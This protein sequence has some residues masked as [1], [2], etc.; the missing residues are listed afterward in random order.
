MS[1]SSFL[2]SANATFVEDLYSEYLKDPNSVL[3]EWK[4]FFDNLD[5]DHAAALKATL[6]PNWQG[7]RYE[8]KNVS[9]ETFQEKTSGNAGIDPSLI[10]K[11]LIKSYREKGHLLAELDPLSM[12]KLP[13]EKE[14]GLSLENFGLTEDGLTKSVS[15]DEEF[16]GRKD[17]AI[18]DLI[19]ALRETYC[20]K[21]GYEIEHIDDESQKIW[22][23][24]RIENFHFHKEFSVED[25][26]ES[27]GVLA[28]VEGF[29]HFL[30]SR[31]PGAK[32]F[33]VEGGDNS[34]ICV[35]KIIKLAALSGVEDITVGMSHRG[36]LNMLAK[37]FNKPYKALLAE[38]Q[39]AYAHPEILDV[40]GD[41]KYHLGQSTDLEFSGHKVHVSLPPNPSHLEATNPVVAGRV[42]AK[43]TLSGDHE[44]KK[45][46][47]I[48]LH[49]DAAFCGE[50]VVFESLMLEGLKAYATG[51]T[52]HIIINNQIGFTATQQKMRS[53]RYCTEVAKVTKAPIIHVNGNCADDVMKAAKI[54]I[55]FRQ[56][57]GR[58]VIIDIV[59]YRLHGHN[60]MDEP[61]FT[62]PEMYKYIAEEKTPFSI[63]ATE[64]ME[65]RLISNEEI[66]NMK[67]EF[68][69]RLDQALE[70]SK[71]YKSEKADWLEGVWKNFTNKE[72]EKSKQETGVEVKKLKEIGVKLAT[73][74]ADFNAHKTI[75]RGYAS[76]LE[77]IKTGINLDWGCAEMLAFGSLLVEGNRVRLTGQD[78]RRGTFSQRQSVLVD[79]ENYQE[80]IP[81][82]NISTKQ[83]IYEAEDSPLSE[84]AVLGFEYGYSTADPTTL[85]IW[86]AQFGDFANNAQAIFDQFVSAAET[87]WL[88][89]S[90]LVVLLPHGYEGQGPEHSSARLERF[91]QL[92]AEDNMRVVNLTTPAN[93]FHALRRQIRSNV[94]KPLIVMTPKSLLRHKL[95]VSNLSDMSNGSKFETV[96][97]DSN[98]Y[99][100]KAKKLVICSGKIYY[101][102][103]EAREEKAIN[104]V[105]IVRLEQFYPFPEESL[106]KIIKEY[107]N[108]NEIVWC[109][110]EPKNMGGW[111]F[112]KDKIRKIITNTRYK[113]KVELE[114]VGRAVSAS[115][116]AGYAKMHKQQQE[117]IIEKIFKR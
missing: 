55:E 104:D 110:E 59:C 7:R 68:K 93:Y 106:E 71:S 115:P 53:T 109:Q 56:K 37:I 112:I 87:K 83:A 29:E 31:F 51:G 38:F 100:S 116:A 36:R 76:R 95:A 74:P 14:V 69:Q 97:G 91:L 113:G 21:A 78:S 23:E 57:F 80:Y 107:K 41:V 65:E 40:S 52:I 96:I 35:R 58:D 33:S 70:E 12:E 94:R 60:E 62:Q 54:A 28:K 88:R 24:D 30:Q 105:A 11:I 44:R 72:T 99:G 9:R 92:C 79:Q 77:S 3:P 103:Y 89:M 6:A 13:T 5:E 48:L 20:S 25:R 39:G 49:G 46:M 15:L 47:S 117:R 26:I 67:S 66:S 84:Y 85:T 27:L 42:R 98:K 43:Q 19:K 101:E 81:L 4:N 2:Y 34:I 64:L 18:G 63:Y 17:W 102:L 73:I 61:R 114:Y 111:N 32:R 82:N 75:R 45:S 90:G 10:A 16:K 1:K 86:E 50:G 8:S 108:L 22:L